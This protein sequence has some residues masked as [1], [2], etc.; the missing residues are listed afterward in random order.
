M[1]PSAG[2]RGETY[3]IA[4][5]PVKRCPAGLCT[6]KVDGTRV[7]LTVARKARPPGGGGACGGADGEQGEERGGEGR[8]LE[9]A[10]RGD[11]ARRSGALVAAGAL[12]LQA[13]RRLG[14]L[15]R[16]GWTLLRGDAARGHRLRGLRIR[17]LPARRGVRVAARPAAL[18]VRARRIVAAVLVLRDGAPG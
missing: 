10:G 15:G 6:R 2:S 16:A 13:A 1:D 11:P 8:E 14:E 5:C 18:V 3:R 4:H 9:D 12:V 17:A 7:A